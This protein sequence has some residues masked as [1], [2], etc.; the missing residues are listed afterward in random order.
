MPIT[1]NERQKESVC[2]LLR[3]YVQ[4]VHNS[5]FDICEVYPSLREFFEY[6]GYITEEDLNTYEQLQKAKGYLNAKFGEGDW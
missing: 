5:P 2:N 4:E 6:V 1:L 3:D